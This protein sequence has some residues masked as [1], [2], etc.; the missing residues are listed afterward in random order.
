MFKYSGDI[1]FNPGTSHG[2]L[3][4]YI[5]AES[6]VLEFGCATGY[7][8]RYLREALGCTVTGVEIDEGAIKDALPYLETGI[9]CD[10]ETYEWE[11]HIENKIFDV[12]VFADVLEH[13]RNPKMALEHSLKYLKDD[14]RILF[15]IPN[16]AH[17]DIILKRIENRFD[18]SDTGILDN[19]HVYF[20][21]EKN[22]NDFCESAGLFLEKQWSLLLFHH[23]GPLPLQRYELSRRKLSCIWKRRRR[24]AGRADF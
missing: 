5:E 6:R 4:K 1:T 11:R 23:Q 20:L 17:S 13:L 19:P 15:S 9:C 7:F 8:S 14:G 16:I 21:G 12:I 3:V 24:S 22:I 18:Y 2:E 10:I